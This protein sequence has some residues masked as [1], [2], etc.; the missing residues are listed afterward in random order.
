VTCV[1]S[2]RA[3]LYWE[4]DDGIGELDHQNGEALIRSFGVGIL[5][6][7]TVAA[8]SLLLRRRRLVP[9][10]E[11]IKRDRRRVDRFYAAGL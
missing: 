2:L 9:A 1:E 8:A 7:A 10:G 11:S 6:L 4:R 3:S 5:A